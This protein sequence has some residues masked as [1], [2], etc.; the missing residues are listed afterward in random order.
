MRRLAASLLLLLPALALSAPL[1]RVVPA[2]RPLACGA[3]LLAG[4]AA[5]PDLT[6][7]RAAPAR[8]SA[9][10]APPLAPLFSLATPASAPLPKALKASTVLIPAP[11]LRTGSL[12]V[13][14]SS[15][16]DEAV[17]A[18]RR[19]ESAA[20]GATAA[21][22][23]LMPEA[24]LMA[25]FDG[26]RPEGASGEFTP[27]HARPG[28]VAQPAMM[29]QLAKNVAMLSREVEAAVPAL[30]RSVNLGEWNGPNTVLDGPCCGDAA[31]KLAALLRMRGYPA[32]LV[33][34]EFHFYVVVRFPEADVV[35]DPTFRQF[36]GREKAPAAVPAVFV[37]TW[38]ALDNAFS[39]HQAHKTTRHGP[40][41][42]YR[43]ESVAREETL[44]GAAL[45]LA[46]AR[47]GAEH[48]PLR[49]RL[50]PPVAAPSRPRLIVP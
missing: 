28:L 41:R 24:E 40:Q 18:S 29:G 36:F 8:A 39:A 7:T 10:T 50:A 22:A 37:G 45:A 35:V 47:A 25:L 48:A 15:D 11:V 42:I 13:A 21:G 2:V 5:T 43:S 44:R 33:E 46:D 16:V 38:A 3:C 4:G 26:S 30:R 32:V 19:A 17:A 1:A 23:A 14:A 49:A 20:D 12:I 27:I 9:L 34:A 31:P 6:L